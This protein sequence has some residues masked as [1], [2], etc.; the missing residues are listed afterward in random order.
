MMNQETE[1]KHSIKIINNMTN[2]LLRTKN[3]LI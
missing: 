1:L 3:K 2:D